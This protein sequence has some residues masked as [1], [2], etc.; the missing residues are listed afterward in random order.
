M[1]KWCGYSNTHI[2][3]QK[4][5]ISWRTTEPILLYILSTITNNSHSKNKYLEDKCPLEC[6]FHPKVKSS[7]MTTVITIFSY[8]I[9]QISQSNTRHAYN[10]ST[11]IK[12][13]A[14]RVIEQP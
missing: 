9:K 12:Q 7:R 6:A 14:I 8:E 13:S 2:R 3:V 11:V 4:V 1:Y 5:S 10:G